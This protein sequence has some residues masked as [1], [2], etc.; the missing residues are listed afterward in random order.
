MKTFACAASVFF[1]VATAFSQDPATSTPASAGEVEALRQQVQSL[2]ETVKTLQQT[3]KDQQSTIERMNQGTQESAEP[4][5]IA[6]AS[7]SPA[8]SVAPR[9]PTED[10]SVV[11]SSGVSATAPASTTN[12]AA[13]AG[14]F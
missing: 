14:G 13:P 12:A 5:P 6:G 11:P 10:T 3:V 8:A 7:P 2:A 9:F 4:S 1:F